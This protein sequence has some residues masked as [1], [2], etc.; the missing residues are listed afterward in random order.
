MTDKY[1]I[2]TILQLKHYHALFTIG[3]RWENLQE[4]LE[5]MSSFP[6]HM[7]F[8]VRWQSPRLCLLVRLIA[9]F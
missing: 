5:E 8:H 9:F 4:Y 2:I 7:I 3:D 1:L 6:S